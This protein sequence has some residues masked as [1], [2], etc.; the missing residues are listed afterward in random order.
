M[1]VTTV[2]NVIGWACLMTSWV[3]PVFMKRKSE[4]MNANRHLVGMLF[5]AIALGFFASAL[6]VSTMK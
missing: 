2:L 6:V 3:A 1:N 4:S 5:G